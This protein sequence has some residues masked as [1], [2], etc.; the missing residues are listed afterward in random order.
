MAHGG[1]R[2]DADGEG[3]AGLGAELVDDAAGEEEAEAVGDLEVDEDVAEVVI[4]DGLMELVGVVIPAHEGSVVE[5][6]LDVAEDVAVHVVD[7]GR[8]EEKEAD[9]PSDVGL[10]GGRGEGA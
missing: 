6:R 3:V 7:G 5:E 4:E 9:E 10:F 8:E 1:E 2:P